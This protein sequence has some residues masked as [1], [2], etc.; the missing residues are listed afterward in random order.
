MADRAKRITVPSPRT[1]F[2]GKDNAKKLDD[3]VEVSSKLNGKEGI[4]YAEFQKVLN[5]KLKELT[6][7]IV[8][9]STDRTYK[10][11]VQHITD[12][13]VKVLEQNGIIGL[14]DKIQEIID[15]DTSSDK[16]KDNKDGNQTSDKILDKIKR[17]L[18]ENKTKDEL[19]DILKERFEYISEVNEDLSETVKLLKEKNNKSDE[20]DDSVAKLIDYVQQQLGILK[21]NTDYVN[22]TLNMNMS[23]MLNHMKNLSGICSLGFRGIKFVGDKLGKHLKGI[24]LT[25]GNILKKV[26]E[27][28]FKVVLKALFSPP[29]LFFGSI[30]AGFLYGIFDHY[31]GWLSFKGVLDAIR[32]FSYIFR[33]PIKTIKGIFQT[34]GSLGKFIGKIVKNIFNSIKNTKFG[35]I[36]SNIIRPIKNAFKTIL[37]PVQSVIKW[38]KGLGKEG[39][40]VQKATSI[41]GGKIQSVIKGIGKV[42]KPLGTIIGKIFSPIK[43][44]IGV[45]SGKTVAKGAAKVAGRALG[46][47]ANVGFAAYDGM[48]AYNKFKEGD[49]LGGIVKSVVT[50]LDAIAI[51]P[52]IG[53]PFGAIAGLID[54]VYEL[55]QSLNVGDFIAGVID[56]ITGFINNF[57]DG[58]PDFFSKTLPEFI[59]DVMKKYNQLKQYM[60]NTIV[61][62]ISGFYTTYIKPEIDKAVGFVGDIYDKHIKPV[63]D[64]I[65]GFVGEIYDKHVKPV[66]DKVL[67]FIGEI[68]DKHIKPVIDPLVNK[69]A[70]LYNKYLKPIVD[71]IFKWIKDIYDEYV[72]PVF[73]KIKGVFKTLKDAFRNFYDNIITSKWGE[74]LLKVFN[75]EISDDE[76]KE[77][78]DRVQ[79]REYISN[80]YNK[81]SFSFLKELNNLNKLNDRITYAQELIKEAEHNMQA[82]PEKAAYY[83]QD[84]EDY[85]KAIEEAEK[86]KNDLSQG[87]LMKSLSQ[88][89]NMKLKSLNKS[90]LNDNDML[91]VIEDVKK[92]MEMT[93]DEN[94]DI[95]LKKLEEMTKTLNEKLQNMENK[96]D[97]TL[98]TVNETAQVAAIGTGAGILGLQKKESVLKETPSSNYNQPGFFY[99]NYNWL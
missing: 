81:S 86:K 30:V 10:T 57:I 17:Y 41:I 92:Q 27:N 3:K 88:A 37:K 40:L 9:N 59:L 50:A 24:M 22:Q 53:A 69:I 95:Y 13:I 4:L 23:N 6:E 77:A 80:L 44:V 72:K 61:G 45:I 34:I 49:V 79:K 33:N 38:I 29:G 2:K 97:N 71:P 78:K 55:V 52:G 46:T 56:K 7:A 90:K 32:V 65:L 47:V 39:G 26:S 70:E 25:C 36:I 74:L 54:M 8:G 64:K 42:F 60:I 89:M 85:K 20:E 58:I 11:K 93:E 87:P 84:I 66:I 98:K 96:Q 83:K 35:K 73:E 15:N 48:E 75:I 12:S 63:V 62:W 99:Q 14:K 67:G 43:K 68:Y 94:K 5:E 82:I 21:V 51:I 76:R 91:Q 19:I 16:S 1:A 18:E 28:L 31:L